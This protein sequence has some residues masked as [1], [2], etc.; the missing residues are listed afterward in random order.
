VVSRSPGPQS[1]TS[2]RSFFAKRGDRYPPSV[3]TCP[4]P[5]CPPTENQPKVEKPDEAL[6]E[7][8]PFS[9]SQLA[10]WLKV[11]VATI[12]AW[13]RMGYGP[14]GNRIG[15]RI[16]YRASDLQRWM[17]E[18]GMVQTVCGGE[19][20]GTYWRRQFTQVEG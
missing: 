7:R 8:S 13:R 14:P 4:N 16:S 1:R 11:P 6:G 20:G 2:S 5:E 3:W 17:A 18:Q 15:K 9:T 10:E 19:C 12:Y